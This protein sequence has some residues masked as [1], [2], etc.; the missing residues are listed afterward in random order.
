MTDKI[1]LR[2]Q[3]EELLERL[4]G[5]W[6]EKVLLDEGFHGTVREDGTPDAEANR[7]LILGARL[8][9]T[10]STAWRVTG[11]AC[12]RDAAEMLYRYVSGHFIDP[13]YG[14]AFFEIT[15]DGKPA[16]EY[17]HIYGE[18]FAI[19]AFAAYFRA[20]GDKTALNK[21][22]AVFTHLEDKAHDKTF[23]GYA[24]CLHRD[25][26]PAPEILGT[27]QNPAQQKTMNTS[28][29]VLEALTALL[30][31]HENALVRERLQEMFDIFLER[32][33]DPDT[34]HFWMFFDRAWAHDGLVRSYGHDI[35]GT[36]LL[37]EAA[38]ALGDAASLEKARKTAIFMIDRTLREAMSPEGV[39]TTEYDPAT[40]ERRPDYSWWEQNEA[41]VACFNAWQITGEQAYLDQAAKTMDMILTRHWDAENGG[42]FPN[43]NPDLSP[44]RG[45]NKASAW[46]CPYHNGRMCLELMERIKDKD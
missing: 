17:K 23:G 10:Y 19:Y 7:C 37:C 39:L 12:Y 46:I 11:N 33:L 13:V 5:W 6:Q 44:K 24:E 34:G 29:H 3:A 9:W 41:V 40:G 20:T 28:L 1:E 43:L 31:V 27:N 45:V 22:M 16:R 2:G 26:T 18:A 14:G 36:W 30:S 38:E 4:L 32:I 21:A 25:G 35:E 42:Y 8:L 15:H